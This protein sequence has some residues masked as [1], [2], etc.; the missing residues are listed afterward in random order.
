M[1]EMTYVSLH[2]RV[3]T[4][5]SHYVIWFSEWKVLCKNKCAHGSLPFY[6][7]LFKEFPS[8]FYRNIILFIYLITDF[9]RIGFILFIF[10][11]NNTSNNKKAAWATE[12]GKEILVHMDMTC[13]WL[14][15][16]NRVLLDY[17]VCLIG[18]I[19]YQWCGQ[20]S[21]TTVTSAISV[22]CS[23][24]QWIFITV[25]PEDIYLLYVLANLTYIISTA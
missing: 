1:E 20:D 21:R 7:G 13:I 3:E 8:S 14:Y 6:V 11:Q 2:N 4:W 10:S 5:N 15:E 16:L 25:D 9:K 18:K 17:Y 24:I 19:M 23:P 12:V 22:I